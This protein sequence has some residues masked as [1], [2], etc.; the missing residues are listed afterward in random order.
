[1]FV[2]NGPPA[3][4]RSDNGGE[5]T[6]ATACEWL[7]RIEMKT[8]VSCARQPLRE[9][10]QRGLQR[11]IRRRTANC[12][13]FYSAAETRYLIEH[14]RRQ[15]NQVLAAQLARL[16]TAGARRRLAGLS[17][18]LSLEVG[19]PTEVRSDEGRRHPGVSP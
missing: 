3:F 4:I 16:Y 1:M 19:P 10:L 8:L 5:L 11:E 2:E 15:Y 7:H 13:I 14:W 6:A 18:Q 17:V 12:H 9:P